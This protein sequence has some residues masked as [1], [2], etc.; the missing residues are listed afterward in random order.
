MLGSI[1]R[2]II[3]EVY[4]YMDFIMLMIDHCDIHITAIILQP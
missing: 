4:T 3:N 2:T 1:G